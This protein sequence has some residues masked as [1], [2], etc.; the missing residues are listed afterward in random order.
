MGD[1]RLLDTL[2]KSCDASKSYDLKGQD[3]GGITHFFGVGVPCKGLFTFFVCEKNSL[4]LA[5]HVGGIFKGYTLH[6][7]MV[8]AFQ[9]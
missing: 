4:I 3:Y 9:F 5:Y 7:S 8:L 1:E 6:L 2:S